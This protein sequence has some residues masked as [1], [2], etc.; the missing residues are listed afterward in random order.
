M[1]IEEILF[2]HPVKIKMLMKYLLKEVDE[3]NV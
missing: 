1:K 2:D 3:S